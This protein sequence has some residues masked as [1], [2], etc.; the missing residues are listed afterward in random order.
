MLI[1]PDHPHHLIDTRV[2]EIDRLSDRGS[3]REIRLCRR[4]ID[5]RNLEVSVHIAWSEIAPGNK[6]DSE[7]PKVVLRDVIQ[8][9]D[10]IHL[11]AG[12]K[13]G[14]R[15]KFAGITS[16]QRRQH[17]KTGCAN[18]GKSADSLQHS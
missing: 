9:Y 14:H 1:V 18:P 16:R 12:L 5:D 11:G 3:A 4:L 6:P 10:P 2:S 7:G 15:D 8:M 17:G 13:A